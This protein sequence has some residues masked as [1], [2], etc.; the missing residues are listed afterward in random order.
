MCV[1]STG[2]AYLSYRIHDVQY[3]HNENVAR[4]V[5]DVRIKHASGRKIVVELASIINV[6]RRFVQNALI[7]NNIILRSLLYKANPSYTMKYTFYLFV[8]WTK[9]STICKRKKLDVV[10]V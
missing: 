1:G 3:V 8:S 4:R 9:M 5:I 7:R 2:S 6:P 10:V